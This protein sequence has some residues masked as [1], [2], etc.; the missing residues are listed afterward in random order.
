MEYT[1]RMNIIELPG[2]FRMA[3][4]LRSISLVMAKYGLIS[5][6][7][8]LGG[9]NPVVWVSRL[10][11]QTED[12][13]TEDTRARLIRDIVEDLGTTY[14]KFGQWLSVRPDFVPPE[15]LREFEHLQDRLAPVPFRTV[16]R[17]IR[18]ELG[19]PL[20]EVFAE[21]DPMPLST[22]SIAQVHRAVL[23]TG[24]EVAVKVQHPNLKRLITT[25]IRILRAMATR[26][27]NT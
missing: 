13:P 2:Q 18:Q 16:R 9:I 21:F 22:A 12:L 7:E 15:I 20:E 3:N 10:L 25:D 1:H 26:A 6:A 4:R 14:I 24:E 5:T 11:G 19:K 8:R 27:V 17:T 23:H